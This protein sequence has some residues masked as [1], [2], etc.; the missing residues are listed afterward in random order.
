MS[1]LDPEYRSFF[2]ETDRLLALLSSMSAMAAL[3]RT[4]IAEIVHLRLAI[5]LENHMKII[6]S[7]LCCGATYIDG[8]PPMLLVRQK[9][10]AAAVAAMKT[11][12]RAKPILLRWNDGK[13]I[14]EGVEPI[15]DPLDHSVSLIQRFG[16][17]FTEIRY[18]RNHID[19]K[20][21]GTR[22]NFRKLLMTYYGA[23]VPGVTSG[24]LLLSATVSKQSS[25]EVPIRRW[26]P[27]LHEI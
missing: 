11:L 13:E 25:A 1:Q 18:I 27:L 16:T 2:K 7:K 9:S 4:L 5:L 22:T 14:R 15:L 17:L 3:H 10:A 12:H 24:I 26:R 6:F 20:N 23:N 8:S 21:D 19:H